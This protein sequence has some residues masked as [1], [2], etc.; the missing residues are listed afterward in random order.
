M[1]RGCNCS[2]PG[3]LANML[4]YPPTQAG[5]EC[6]RSP[7]PCCASS[8]DLDLFTAEAD[9]SRRPAV[10]GSAS[11]FRIYR[12]LTCAWAAIFL[13][14]CYACLL[15]SSKRILSP[16]CRRHHVNERTSGPGRGG[17]A[18]THPHPGCHAC[19]Q[20]REHAQLRRAPGRASARASPGCRHT[21]CWD[22]L[23]FAIAALERSTT[24]E[25]QALGLCCASASQTAR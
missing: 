2:Y 4:T 7:W 9:Q 8:I 15:A 11:A 25:A 18:A 21:Y 16:S 3:S 22:E 1:T 23:G 19:R 5:I 10:T 24:S 14:S 17:E 12:R 6:E 20:R 13:C